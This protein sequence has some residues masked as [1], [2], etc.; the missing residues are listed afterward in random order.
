MYIDGN[1]EAHSYWGGLEDGIVA[2]DELTDLAPEGS[3]EAVD[4][5]K[6]SIINEE[7]HVFEGPI[8]DQSG[9]IKVE[10]GETLTDDEMLNIMWFVDGVIGN[11]N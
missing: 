11:I 4:A 5:A 9:E 7:I 10:A 2:L 1:F 8:K 6:E 3:K